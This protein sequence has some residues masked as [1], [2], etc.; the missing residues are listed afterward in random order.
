MNDIPDCT[1]IYSPCK[2]YAASDECFDEMSCFSDDSWGDEPPPLNLRASGAHGAHGILL[3]HLAPSCQAQLN[4][5]T[6][7]KRIGNMM[8]R[9]MKKVN[10]KRKCQSKENKPSKEHLLAL[11]AAGAKKHGTTSTQ[12]E[13]AR[14]YAEYCDFIGDVY[15]KDKMCV[16]TAFEYLQYT[17]WR[18]KRKNG[19]YILK[20][21]ADGDELRKVRHKRNPFDRLEYEKVMAMLAK[22]R[23]Q[24]N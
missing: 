19:A 3:T 1:H 15:G 7:I 20:D 23:C 14:I 2:G 4:R 22:R 18:P 16:D 5:L 12:E 9:T 17:A 24:N 6:E 13:Y 21:G 11:V 10:G 8:G